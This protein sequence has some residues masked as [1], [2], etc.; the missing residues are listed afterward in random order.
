MPRCRAASM[1]EERSLNFAP[2]SSY[3]VTMIAVACVRSTQ[4]FTFVCVP[5]RSKRVLNW[6]VTLSFRMCGVSWERCWH[7][8]CGWR[9]PMSFV[10]RLFCEFEPPWPRFVAS[11]M[12]WRMAACSTRSNAEVVTANDCTVHRVA[13]C[14][15]LEPFTITLSGLVSVMLSSFDWSVTPL[16]LSVRTNRVM[17]ST[18]GFLRS[19]TFLM[20]LIVSP[21][22]RAT[23][24]TNWV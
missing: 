6:G 24:S 15:A 1:R 11:S 2:A 12:M 9:L 23:P 17:Q 16:L 3:D 18:L 21:L 22:T 4:E 20:P 10:R 7:L 19:Y 13:T 5:Q 14:A 8:C